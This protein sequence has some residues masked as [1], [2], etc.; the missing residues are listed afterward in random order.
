M[1]KQITTILAGFL[2]GVAVF[3]LAGCKK[4]EQEQP[5]LETSVWSTY[6]TTK[7]IRQTSRNESYQKQDARLSAQMMQNEYEG[8]Q[9]IVTAGEDI[10]YNLTA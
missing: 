2:V 4:Q 10:T 9:L 6:N 1:K 8:A 5:K 3:T 7:V